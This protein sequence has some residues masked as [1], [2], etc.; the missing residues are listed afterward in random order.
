MEVRLKE[1]SVDLRHDRF[2]KS[3]LAKH[4]HKTSHQICLEKAKIIAKVEHHT[5][6]KV[7]EKMEIEMNLKVSTKMNKLK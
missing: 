2:K 6:R 4:S 1:H 7:H 3:S 5:K